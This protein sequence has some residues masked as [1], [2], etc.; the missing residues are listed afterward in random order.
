MLFYGRVELTDNYEV[1]VFREQFA[2]LHASEGDV[3]VVLLARCFVK[4]FVEED[5]RKDVGIVQQI[6]GGARQALHDEVRKI[7]V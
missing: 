2:P 1:D 7:R 4:E 3:A 6:V 5:E